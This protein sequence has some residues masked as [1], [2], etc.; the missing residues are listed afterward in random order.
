MW[1]PSQILD[2]MQNPA[3][4][5]LTSFELIKFSIQIINNLKILFLGIFLEKVSIKF[6]AISYTVSSFSK[7]SKSSFVNGIA[8]SIDKHSR[9][10]FNNS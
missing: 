10:Y 6:N 2:K 8:I 9:V 5:L 1:V 3:F 7:F 4:I